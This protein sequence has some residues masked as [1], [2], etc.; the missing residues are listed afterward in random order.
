MDTPWIRPAPLTGRFSYPHC[1][2][3]VARFSSEVIAEAA[4]AFLRENDIAVS[5]VGH[6]LV[7]TVSPRN[8]VRAMDL[9]VLSEA[10]RRRAE[11]LLEE[12]HRSPAVPEDG[13]EDRTTAP[14]LSRLDPAITLACPRC[15]A[16]LP[17]DAAIRACPECDSDVDPVALIVERH[18]PEA[19][20]P[21]YDASPTP[22]CAAAPVRCPSCDAPVPAESRRARCHDCGTL[23]DLDHPA[24]R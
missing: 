23:Y 17:R 20:S 21:C 13:W 10:E 2:F 1:M 3:R 22:E 12:F 24:R 9:L 4:A 11:R 15:N 19:L 8:V 18:G 7:E 14:D 16:N 6:M 5:V